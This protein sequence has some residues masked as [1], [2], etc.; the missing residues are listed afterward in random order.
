MVKERDI[1]ILIAKN[2]KKQ[3][4]KKKLTQKELAK[5]TGYSYAY[6]RRIEAPRCS[7]NF[8]ILTLYNICKAINIKIGSL[9]EDDD[10]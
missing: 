5:I 2:L 9:F 3:R 10:I 4:K 7:K 1:Y 6:I 8:S